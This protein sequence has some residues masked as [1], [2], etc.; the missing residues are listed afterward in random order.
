MFNKTIDPNDH[1]IKKYRTIENFLLK[2]NYYIE[3]NIISTIRNLLLITIGQ[4]RYTLVEDHFRTNFGNENYIYPQG[5][6]IIFSNDYI[7]PIRKKIK[8]KGF[9]NTI[10]IIN[11]Y[12]TIENS[13]GYKFISLND[14]TEIINTLTD[15]LIYTIS[16]YN[17][18]NIKLFIIIIG[19]IHTLLKIITPDQQT[20]YINPT[21][22]GIYF[23]ETWPY[24]NVKNYL[25]PKNE[26]EDHKKYF[27]SHIL[28]HQGFISEAKEILAGFQKDFPGRS[29]IKD[30]AEYFKTS[31]PKN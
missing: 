18:E 22:S 20:I 24:S 9:I 10:D 23:G 30:M 7:H 14:C 16:K 21:S 13:S 25:I 4:S 12:K 15:N 1:K 28:F 3:D 11:H 29:Y 19:R 17:L 27:N 8:D 26:I 31:S 2:F 6:N 5:Y